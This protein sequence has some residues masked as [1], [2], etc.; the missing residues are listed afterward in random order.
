MH[1]KQ[2]MG[3]NWP[4]TG[5]QGV[6]SGFLQGTKHPNSKLDDGTNIGAGL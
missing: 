3:V 1:R 4:L 5:W 2:R 6:I